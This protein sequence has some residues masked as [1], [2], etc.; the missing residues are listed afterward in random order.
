MLSTTASYRLLTR[1]ID[2]SLDMTRAQKP[3]ANESAYY[4]ENIGKIKSIDAFIKNTRV[5]TFA[6]KAFGLED[7]AHAKAFIRKVL[8][9]G[10]TDP[11]SF[12]RRLNDDRFLAFARAFDFKKN[13]AATTDAP[14]LRQA[15]VDKY[16]R[17]ALELSAGADNEG[18]RLALYFQRTAPTINS[19]YGLLGDA[20]LWKVVKTIFGF[21]DAMANAD[22]EKQAAAITQRL[23]MADLK[24]PVKL[25]KLITRFTA[26]WDVTE[27][28]TTDPVLTLFSSSPPQTSLDLIMTLKSLKYGGS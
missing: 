4:L 5:F 27:V 13:G 2:R 9:E 23:T 20:A 19:P 8:N 11:T 18:V 14:A 25:N 15:V 28:S 6:M 12:A 24:D 26:T 10:V 16:V 17:Q 7:M 1:N 21:P 22:I 3:V